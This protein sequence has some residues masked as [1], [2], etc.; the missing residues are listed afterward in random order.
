MDE[1]VVMAWTLAGFI[2]GAVAGGSVVYRLAV[3]PLQPKTRPG[4]TWAR[5]DV[6]AAEA[7]ITADTFVRKEEWYGAR[8]DIGIWSP[9]LNAPARRRQLLRQSVR[10]DSGCDFLTSNAIPGA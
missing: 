9:C 4:H 5:Q 6:I 3:A 8:T 2:G 7:V 1:Y 10:P